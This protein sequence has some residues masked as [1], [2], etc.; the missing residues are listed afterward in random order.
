MSKT[1]K[2]TVSTGSVDDCFD[3]ARR[4]ARALDRG[5]RLESEITVTFEDVSDMLRVLS[6]ERVRLLRKILEKPESISR[7]AIILKRAPRAVSRDVGILEDF[8]L[9]ST[10]FEKNPGH[11]RR[12]VVEPRADHF[13]LVADL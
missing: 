11:G 9:L 10:H 2:V 13:Q 5:E 4:H 8:G 12:K 3:R 7:L 1:V 6:S